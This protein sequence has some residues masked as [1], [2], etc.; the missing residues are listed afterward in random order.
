MASQINR[1]KT[2]KKHSNMFRIWIL[3]WDFLPIY[4]HKMKE[5]LAHCFCSLQF[6]WIACRFFYKFFFLFRCQI[7]IIYR[8]FVVVVHFEWQS[9]WCVC[10][11]YSIKMVLTIIT[12][13]NQPIRVNELFETV[14]HSIQDMTNHQN[15]MYAIDETL[16]WNRT[17]Y[18][19][20]VIFFCSSSFSSKL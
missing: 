2:H 10:W 20:R 11:L 14:L 4:S 7:I 6:F 13:E 5:S 18:L 3:K 8:V 1:I 15:K 17:S 12:A 19:F 9:L 16:C